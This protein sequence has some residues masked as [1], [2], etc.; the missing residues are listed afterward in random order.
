MSDNK[1]FKKEAPLQGLSGLWGGIASVLTG[2]ASA[3]E[4]MQATGGQVSTYTIADKKYKAHKFA[5]GDGTFAV[6]ALGAA[7]PSD[8]ESVEFDFLL[9][10]GGGGGG[11][12]NANGGGGG[13]AGLLVGTVTAQTSPGQYYV[14]IANGG[15]GRGSDQRGYAGNDSNIT[16][17][18]M[19]QFQ[20]Y[21]GGSGGGYHGGGEAGGSGGG[22]SG[23]GGSGA[24]YG[25]GNQP[26]EPQYPTIS[27]FG[28]PGGPRGGNPQYGGGGGGAGN[29]GGK[30]GTPSGV[31]EA[32]GGDGKAYNYL[33]GSPNTY[34]CGGG[35]GAQWPDQRSNPGDQTSPQGG[36]LGG[37]GC[38]GGNINQP[39]AKG[40]RPGTTNTGGGGGGASDSYGGNGGPGVCVIRYRTND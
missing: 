34:W 37:G 23:P 13:A 5:S 40:G 6:S 21:G 24:P 16:I 4:G 20:A 26:N 38:G 19:K 29:A 10:G 32:K 27:G 33:D 36:G 2:G 18:T 30:Q 35:G 1:W 12:G 22:S 8:P 39:P 9:A 3:F 17:P 25:S 31:P 7:G 15:E 28:N 14:T 11:D